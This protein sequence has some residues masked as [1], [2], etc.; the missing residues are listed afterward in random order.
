MMLLK[1]S[2]HLSSGSYDTL[3][4]IE[5]SWIVT[6]N[7]EIKQECFGHNFLLFILSLLLETI[8]SSA[9]FL[10][11]QFYRY[12]KSSF[13]NL[14]SVR[15][16][17]VTLNICKIVSPHLLSKFSRGQSFLVVAFLEA[18]FLAG[19]YQTFP[20]LALFPPYKKAQHV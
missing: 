17:K 6:T 19:R 18:G 16:T 11:F 20:P 13:Q 7:H 12:K 8:K 15:Y 9:F 2:G 5:V 1:I 4:C 3:R 10:S 14:C